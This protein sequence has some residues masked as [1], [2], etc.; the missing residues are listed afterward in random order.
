MARGAGRRAGKLPFPALRF[1][2]AEKQEN[3]GEDTVRLHPN[4]LLLR[5]RDGGELRTYAQAR[6]DPDHQEQDREPND[7]GKS[8]ENAHHGRDTRFTGLAEWLAINS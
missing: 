4:H 2:S 6:D 3:P 1:R 8:E 7:R 5:S